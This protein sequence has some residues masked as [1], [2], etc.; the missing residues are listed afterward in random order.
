M[1][2][3]PY[4]KACLKENKHVYLFPVCFGNPN[5][6]VHIKSSNYCDGI[7]AKLNYLNLYDYT[8]NP[9]IFII[10]LE[11]SHFRARESIFVTV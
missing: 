4:K 5:S 10:S 7:S 3:E 11:D 9:I 8:F 2:S 1:R 6:C